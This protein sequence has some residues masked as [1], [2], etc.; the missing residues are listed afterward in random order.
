MRQSPLIGS[1]FPISIGNEVWIGAPEVVLPD[2]TIGSGAIFAAGVVVSRDVPS[3]AVVAG[4]SAK[5]IRTI[6]P[7]KG[8]RGDAPGSNSGR[9]S[10]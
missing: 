5:V 10:R 9:Q 7:T 2:V 8:I 1:G 3:Y 4:V 6:V